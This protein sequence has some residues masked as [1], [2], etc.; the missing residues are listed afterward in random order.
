VSLH[1]KYGGWFAFRGVVIF[2]NVHATS[3]QQINPEDL[4][5]DEA[6]AIDLMER[7]V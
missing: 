1:P 3:L 7:Y 5:K 2:P 4:L 6:K